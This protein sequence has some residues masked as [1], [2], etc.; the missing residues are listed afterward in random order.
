LLANASEAPVSEHRSMTSLTALPTRCIIWRRWPATDES[1]SR[2]TRQPSDEELR[3]H[4]RTTKRRH[5]VAQEPALA[6]AHVHPEIQ[7][8]ERDAIVVEGFEE[9][10]QVLERPPKTRQLGND[11][12][13]EL[14]ATTHQIVERR[15]PLGVVVAGVVDVREDPFHFEVSVAAVASDL[16]PVQLWCPHVVPR[17]RDPVIAGDS[18]L[19]GHRELLSRMNTPL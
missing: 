8:H 7:K 6:C 14:V 4:S 10:R 19:I 3:T 16:I 18:S 15:S 17:Y 11:H 5:D 9:L 2:P 13:R 1:S 12:R